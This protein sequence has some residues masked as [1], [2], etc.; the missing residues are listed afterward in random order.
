[1]PELPEV[2]A[3]RL[4]LDRILRNKKISKIELLREKSFP[5]FEQKSVLVLDQKIVGVKR[6]AKVLNFL[7]ENDYS[8]FGSSKNDRSV[9]FSWCRW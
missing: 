8:F 5:D 1:M 9:Y 7:F 2:E 4:K 3:I 6:R